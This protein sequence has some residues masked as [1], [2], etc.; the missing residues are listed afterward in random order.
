MTTRSDNNIVTAATPMQPH[1]KNIQLPSP[2]TVILLCVLQFAVFTARSAVV[3]FSDLPSFLSAAGPASFESF[4][5]TPLLPFQSNPSLDL[6]PFA[7]G[8]DGSFGIVTTGPT[9]GQHPTDG[10]RY[11]AL[12]AR[13]FQLTFAQPIRALALDFI[14]CGDLPLSVGQTLSMSAPASATILQTVGDFDPPN[15][16]EFFFGFVSDVPVTEVTFHTT[17]GDN[18]AMDSIRYSAVPEPSAYLISASGVA[19]LI[20]K[21]RRNGFV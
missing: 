4:E 10:V 17:V 8:S 21:R 5:Q 6:G 1:R 19:W 20:R 9:M 2:R 12:N 3:T 14:D 11:L 16:Y 15:G 18:M 13:T 7:F